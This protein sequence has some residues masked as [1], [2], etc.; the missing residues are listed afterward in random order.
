MSRTLRNYFFIFSLT[1]FS[2]HALIFSHATAQPPEIP[3]ASVRVEPV[4]EEVV[5]PT[6]E[7][8]GTV[9]PSQRSIIGSAVDGRVT[10]YKVDAG[11]KVEFEEELAQL[12]I[13]TISIEVRAA[14]AELRLRQAE[15][16]ELERGARPEEIAQAEALLAA[17]QALESYARSRLERTRQLERAGGGLSAE[18]VDLAI[19]TFRAAE[20]K[21]IENEESLRLL[22]A[23]PREEQIAQAKAR[24]DS[25]SEQVELLKDRRNKYTLKSPFNGYVVREYTEVGAWIKQGDPIAEVVNINPVEIEV[26]VPESTIRFLKP[27]MDVNVRVLAVGYETIA[28][29]ISQIVPEAD[30]RARTFPV[31]IRV[32]NEPEDESRLIRPGMLARVVLPTAESMLGLT[33]SKDAAVFRGESASVYKVADNKAML[34]PV[35]ILAE[36]E[37]K[38]MVSGDLIPGDQVVIRG[39][40]RLRPGQPLIIQNSEPTE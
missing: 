30:S 23:G 2:S 9:N 20:Q 31:K 33:I 29:T 35:R 28:G 13:G 39:N 25:Q 38:F 19:S 18:E 27:G 1:L 21:R 37:K 7:F 8:V 24:F 5:P 16:E 3:P 11:Q 22:K 40:E 36:Y 17:S 4:L 34:V 6:R 26:N 12:L 15:L 14:E 32:T 10:E